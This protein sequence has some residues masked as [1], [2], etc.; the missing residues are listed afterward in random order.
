M[1][2]G[3]EIIEYHIKELAEEGITY[4]PPFEPLSLTNIEEDEA[5]DA[6]VNVD[7]NVSTQ[8]QLTSSGKHSKPNL[9]KKLKNGLFSTKSFDHSNERDKPSEHE[10]H[11]HVQNVDL[12]RS[13][14]LDE[15]S[16]PDDVKQNAGSIVVAD[17][18]NRKS[19]KNSR[20]FLF[21]S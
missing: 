6:D 8:P 1:N 11:A 3:E 9:A 5:V 13:K 17:D 14:S 16:P 15:D 2:K 21:F 4:L 10:K 18:P 12:L 7:Q 20:H 19:T